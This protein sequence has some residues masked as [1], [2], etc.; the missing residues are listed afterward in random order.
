MLS[1]WFLPHNTCF[2]NNTLTLLHCT[3]PISFHITLRWYSNPQHAPTTKR[4]SHLM[5]KA[6]ISSPTRTVELLWAVWAVWLSTE[7]TTFPFLSCNSVIYWLLPFTFLKTASVPNPFWSFK[8]KCKRQP[9][10]YAK[11]Q[12]QADLEVLQNFLG[13]ATYIYIPRPFGLSLNNTW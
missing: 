12:L 10:T 9:Q 11:R 8:E 6:T 7:E 4:G 13:P 5:L 1:S 3:N 2:H